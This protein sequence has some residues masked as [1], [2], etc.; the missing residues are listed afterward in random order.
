MRQEEALA[1]VEYMRRLVEQTRIRA[2]SAAP[3]LL[4]WGP[5]WI[6]GY[7]G[8]LWTP[9]VWWG[10]LPVA[11]VGHL[12]IAYRYHGRHEGGPS[13]LLQRLNRMTAVVM[14]VIVGLYA[15][16]V[17]SDLEAA[18]YWPIAIGVY[19][20]LYGIFVGRELALCGA[21]LVG[22]GIASLFLPYEAALVWLAAAGGG[23]LVVGGVLL[24]GSLRVT[25]RAA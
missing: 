6:V 14:I 12:L 16:V 3:H 9:A 23:G 8:T 5:L 7:L 11:S 19:F 2:A 1:H 17:R 22:I 24:R 4:M 21:W 25:R 18:A 20:V 15:L 13:P 10:V